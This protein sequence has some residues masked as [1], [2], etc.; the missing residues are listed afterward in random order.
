MPETNQ[1]V[2]DAYSQ[3]LHSWTSSADTIR[4]RTNA[5]DSRLREWGDIESITPEQI[6][7]WLA[8]H[9]GWTRATY[10]QHLKSFCTWLYLTGRIEYNPTDDIKAPRQPKS[11]PRPLSEAE[12]RL[13]LADANGREHTWL[14]LGL[15]QGLRAHEIAKIRGSDFADGMLYVL[16][17]GGKPAYLPVHPEIA[18]IVADY[19][20]GYWFPGRV[21]GH[22]ASRTVSHRIAVLFKRHGIDGALHRCRHSFGTSLV[23]NGVHV[24][25]VQNL[26]RHE[27][28]ATTAIYTAL[29]EDELRDAINQLPPAS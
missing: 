28:L 9:D 19:P 10:Y 5:A 18:A 21:D 11:L 3:W 14:L 7:A 4:A 8:K 24:R 26:M 1:Q 23:R 22:I 27:S 13:V 15:Y 17:K 2:I 29:D 25:K 6:E 16:G 12:R 20:R